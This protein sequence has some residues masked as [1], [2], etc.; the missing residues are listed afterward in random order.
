MVSR[1]TKWVAMGP[2]G[3]KIGA[4]EPQ[5]R[6]GAFAEIVG[7]HTTTSDLFCFLLFCLIKKENLE[8]MGDAF[9]GGPDN[10]VAT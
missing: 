8:K 9:G 10:M 4:F 6:C 1:W 3:L 5:S 2:F 7:S